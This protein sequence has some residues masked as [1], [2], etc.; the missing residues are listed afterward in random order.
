MAKQR[1]IQDSFWTDPY[2]ETLDPSEKLLFIYFLTNPLCNVAG[3]YEIRNNRIAYETGF[4]KEMIAKIKERFARD[5]KMITV[6]DWVILT[7][8]AKHQS[9]NPSVLAGM[10]RIIND[11]PEKVQ[12]VTGFDRLSH[13]TLLNLTLP[14]LTKPNLT[15]SEAVV[16][17][18]NSASP[19]DSEKTARLIKAMENIDPKNKMNYGRKV[20]RDACK[21]LIEQYG[22]EKVLEVIDAIP[23][24]KK[25]IAYF[26]SITTP[27]ELQE[28][29]VK[30]FD[31]VERH[32]L[33]NKTREIA[34]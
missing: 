15:Q 11:L 5:K 21:F 19:E 10:Q 2:I 34:I 8:F 23:Q 29:W 33:Q 4:D 3:I 14:N 12:A 13:F 20:Q 28:K 22:F 1:Y 16:D 31:A 18:P 24:I 17:V 32:K 9:Q 30:A 25:T 7:N 27:L 26:P 6:D